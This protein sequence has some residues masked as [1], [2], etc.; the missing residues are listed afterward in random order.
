[1]TVHSTNREARKRLE[2]SVGK[3]SVRHFI[4]YVVN[5]RKIVITDAKENSTDWDVFVVP[6]CTVDPHPLPWEFKISKD[7]A[8]MLLKEGETFYAVKKVGQ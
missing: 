1:M 2:A 5:G 3:E 8:I 7:P 4:S 6:Q